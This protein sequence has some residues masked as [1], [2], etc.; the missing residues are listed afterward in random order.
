[1]LARAVNRWDIG[2][3]SVLATVCLLAACLAVPNGA[4]RPYLFGTVVELEEG[5]EDVDPNE[6]PLEADDG[7]LLL[8]SPSR[9]QR[10]D[11]QTGKFAASSRPSRQRSDSLAR[12]SRS[13]ELLGRNGSGGPL[14][15]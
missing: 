15:C 12:I 7:D 4:L 3:C 5:A 9:V 8:A 10:L 13:A 1:M 11:R 6:L 2:R 14:R